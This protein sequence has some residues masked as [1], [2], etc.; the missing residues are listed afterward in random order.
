MRKM[1]KTWKIKYGKKVKM[2]NAENVENVENVEMPAI[3]WRM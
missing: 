2:R 1:R 3:F